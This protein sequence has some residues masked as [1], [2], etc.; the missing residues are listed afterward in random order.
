MKQVIPDYC[1]SADEQTREHCYN[2]P[3]RSIYLG[4]FEIWVCEECCKKWFDRV[5]RGVAN[6]RIDEL[7]RGENDR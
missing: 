5:F 4:G 7:S 1:A 2:K 3:E 6:E